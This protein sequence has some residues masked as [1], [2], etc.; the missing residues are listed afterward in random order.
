M[1][2]KVLIL[3]GSPRERGNSA[4]LADAAAEGARETGAEVESVYLHALR[5]LPCSACEGCREP[6]GC[7]LDDDM[8]DLL[9]KVAAADSILFATPVYWFTLSAQLKL[10]IDRWY[11]FQV[12]GW[13]ELRGTRFGV[14][15]TYGDTD[16]YSS[17]GINAVNTFETMARFLHSPIAGIV[18]GS[19]SDVGDVEKHPELLDQAKELGRRLGA[20][21]SAAC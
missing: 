4:V 5:I 10:C 13:R 12:S 9:P 16:L 2:T 20:D 15:L 21:R 18:H 11:S 19:V 8:R 1:A 17:G 7:V 14:V 3:K 6:G